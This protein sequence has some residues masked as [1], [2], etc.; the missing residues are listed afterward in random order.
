MNFFL[1]SLLPTWLVVTII[2]Y[3]FSI[4]AHGI[5]GGDMFEPGMNMPSNNKMSSIAKIRAVRFYLRD[6]PLWPITLPV[7]VFKSAMKFRKIYLGWKEEAN[8]E[9][10][11]SLNSQLIALEES[12]D[13][14]NKLDKKA[15]ETRGRYQASLTKYKSL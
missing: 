5:T 12:I 2:F 1:N 7:I 9:A 3:A 14:K 8:A 10:L 11:D 13:K 6:V 15:Q 4:I